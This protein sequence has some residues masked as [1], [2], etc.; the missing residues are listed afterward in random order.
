MKTRI[1]AFAALAFVSLAPLSVPVGAADADSAVEVRL[2][3]TLKATIQQLRTAENDRATLQAA[4][5]ELEQK[6]KDLA[7]Q[8]KTLIKQAGTDKDAADKKAEDLKA[9]L[10]RQVQEIAQLKEALAQAQTANAKAVAAIHTGDERIN[11][12]ET[13]NGTLQRHVAVLQTKNR[14]LFL[15]A[16]EILTRYDRFGLGEALAAKEPFVG[17]TRTKLENLVQ[18]YQDKL[19]DQRA[20]P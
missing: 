18:D 14:A 4:Q 5:T 11:G 10:A 7:A 13:H 2:R 20:Q 15:L 6:N 9:Q 17:V 8:V 12:L 19:R 1:L 3:E 16:N